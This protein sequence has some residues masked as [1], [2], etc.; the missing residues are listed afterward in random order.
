MGY[1]SR[2]LWFHH[3]LN[4]IQDTLIIDMQADKPEGLKKC[5]EFS[6]QEAFSTFRKKK[7]PFI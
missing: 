2:P 4:W 1:F 3:P 7:F 5:R 6:K